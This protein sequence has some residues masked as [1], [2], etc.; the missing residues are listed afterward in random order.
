MRTCHDFENE[1]NQAL[2]MLMVGATKQHVA[3]AFC[4]SVSTVT[5]L[6]QGVQATGSVRGRSRPGQQRVTTRRQDR[7]MRVNH[8]RNRF[9]MATQTSRQ[10][11]GR[12]G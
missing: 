10:T 6:A 5:R 2:G 7:Q 12:H 3:N 9:Q 11:V 8:L 4:C 1:R